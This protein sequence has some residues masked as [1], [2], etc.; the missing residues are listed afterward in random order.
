LLLGAGLAFGS[1]VIDGSH[2]LINKCYR[3]P[4]IDLAQAEIYYLYLPIWKD[5]YI[6]RAEIPMD[7][8][9]LQ[10]PTILNDPNNLTERSKDF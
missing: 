7:D 6:C 5:Q 10:F 2:S 3:C 9:W 4:P 1:H 8:G